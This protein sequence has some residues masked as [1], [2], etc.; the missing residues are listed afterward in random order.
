LREA[1]SPLAE[2]GVR[3]ACIVQARPQELRSLCGP[4][5][6]CIADPERR[7][8]AALG[9]GRMGLWQILMSG[10]LRQR[11]AEAARRGFRQD[12]KRT[13]RRESDALLL[14]GAVLVQRGGRILWLHRGEHA[15][16]LP[17]AD[18]LV[19]IASEFATPVRS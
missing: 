9:L 13:L 4:G 16:D 2:R 8:H 10:V 19:A 3:L 5:L 11:R 6:A 7:S 15:A 1:V 14:P 17:R 18:E 12:W